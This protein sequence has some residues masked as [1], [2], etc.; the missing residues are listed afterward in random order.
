MSVKGISNQAA[1]YQGVDKVAASTSNTANAVQGSASVGTN[2]T[3]KAV[4]VEL[5]N[6]NS[7]SSQQKEQ[8]AEIARMKNAINEVNIKLRPTRTR[9]EFSYHEEVNRVSIKVFNK[10]TNEIIREIPPEESYKALEKI[11]EIAGLL[12]DEKR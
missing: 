9:C 10:E 5:G 7:E 12:I 4:T 8:N 1:T 6:T 3:Q 11:W 2:S